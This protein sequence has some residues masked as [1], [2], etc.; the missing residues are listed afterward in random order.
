MAGLSGNY[1]PLFNGN[2]S[3]MAVNNRALN[4]VNVVGGALVLYH[5]KYDQL[6]R[7]TGMDAYNG[8][9]TSTDSW[10]AMSVMNYF[11]ERVSYDANGNILNYLRHGHK[12]N[13]V[14][15]NLT[16]SYG[17]GN[18]KLIRVTDTVSANRYGPDAGDVADIDN[19]A[20]NNYTYDETGNLIRDNAEGITNIKWSVYGKILEITRNANAGNPVQKITY[21]YDAQGNRIS[22]TVLKNTGNKT[23]TW[24][25]RDA[26][27]NVMT[28]YSSQGNPTDLASLPLSVS[29]RHLYGSSRLGLYTQTVNADNG[30]KDMADSNSVKYY[31]GFRQYE[32][33]NHLGNVLATISDKKKPV[34]AGSDAVVDYFDA[35]VTTAQ[36]YYP[37]GMLMGGRIGYQSSTGWVSETGSSAP[38]NGLAADIAVDSRTDN[39]PAEYTA[40]SSVEMNPGFESGGGD[41]FLAYISEDAGGGSGG[42]S[43]SSLNG[44]YRYGFNGK[45]NDNEVKGTGNQQDYGMRIYDPRLGRFLSVD[46]LYKEYAELTPYQYASNTPIQA[47]DIDGE[48]GGYNMNSENEKRK[49]EGESMLK[50]LDYRYNILARVQ[51]AQTTLSTAKPPKNEYELLRLQSVE[52]QEFDKVGRNPD[53]TRKPLTKLANNKTFRNFAD[54]VGLPLLEGATLELGGSALFRGGYLLLRSVPRTGV[55]VLGKYPDYLNLASELGAKRFNIPTKI[56][57]KMSETEQW[58]ANTKFLD[59]MILRDDK[60]IL[61]N[62]VLN[63]NKVTG[64]FRKEL[65]YLINKGYDLSKDG[66]QMLKNAK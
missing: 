40:T 62:P 50:Q 17:S 44:S 19:Q 2:I 16:Y 59:R 38:D 4:N 7:L 39:Q 8:F 41:T 63:I 65:D 18:N 21:T 48:E 55:T 64:V 36:D 47:I 20:A 49:R 32:L 61:S 10:S 15:D 34:D 33:S 60:I 35:D 42:G 52:R 22:K 6:N 25:V 26:Q 11:K 24:Y 12:A 31:R 58:S 45:E 14:M 43:G 27:G 66:T 30:P 57:N 3:S 56:W 23:Y 28:T 54:N 53:G 51:T 13:Y 46:P 9:N 1:R 29:E 5:Y 37:F